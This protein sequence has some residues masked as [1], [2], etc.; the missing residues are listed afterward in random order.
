MRTS[1][2]APRP[3]DSF[4]GNISGSIVIDASAVNTGVPGSYAVTYDVRIA[5]GNAA[6]TGHP[7]RQCRDTTAPV[8]TLSRR[9]PADHRGRHRLRRTRRHRQRHAGRRPHRQ[10]RDRRHGGQPDHAGQLRRDLRRHDA[11]G[12]AADT[13]HPHRQ[14]RRHHA[15]GHHAGRR[16]PADHR[17]RHRLRR[18]RRH[19]QRHARRRPHRLASSST[20]LP[21]TPQRPAATS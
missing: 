12:N 14:R 17:G 9:Q 1:N 16:Q 2:S 6:T 19:R 18:T 11:A 15:A 21:S 10:H 8:I 3:V 13:G 5:A 7:H 4:D 20:P